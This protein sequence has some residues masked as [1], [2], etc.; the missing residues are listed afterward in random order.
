MAVVV[1]AILVA[2]VWLTLV[3]GRG[4]FWQV[5]EAPKASGPVSHARVVAVIPARNEASG[6]A[7]TIGS[8][9]RQDQPG[10]L[11]IVLVDDHSSDGTAD[12][13][14][15]AAEAAG[16]EHRLEIIPAR[17]LPPQWTGKLWAVSEGLR[18][19]GSQR[20]DYILL[21]DADI[22]H[23]PDN[24]SSLVRMAERDSLDL[25]SLM[26]RLSTATWAEKALIPAFVFFFFMLY[27]PRWA[28]NP[29][30]KMAAAAGGCM[31]VRPDIL[32]RIGGIAAIRGAL[33]DDCAL[34]LAIKS[35]GGRIRLDPSRHTLS[36]R[37][38]GSAAEIWEMI[39]RTAFTQL[40]YSAALLFGTVLAMSLTF[41]APPLL[42]LLA[43]GPAQWLGAGAWV[44]M[45]VAYYPTLRLYDRSPLWALA[46][47]L[48]AVFY[49]AA[50]VGSAINYWRG[51]GGQWKGRAQALRS[52]SSAA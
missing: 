5:R 17:D 3:F 34:A 29:R 45:A 52:P 39:A 40:H 42:T 19:A 48:V 36:S 18:H 1:C 51:R 12:L 38:Y 21:S 31:L 35:A 26:V 44:A 20:P 13:A 8:L 33:I 32:D 2:I 23:A 25:V 16:A 37:V 4:G 47:P 27:P 22:T 6:I 46:L 43:R 50:T 11:G 10:D 9:L 15:A 14:R 30:S 41:L 28:A 24:V 49:S 7:A